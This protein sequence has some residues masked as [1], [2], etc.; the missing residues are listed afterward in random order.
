[1]NVNIVEKRRRWVRGLDESLQ[2]AHET[3]NHLQRGDSK[4][5]RK[6]KPK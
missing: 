5:E 4:G 1:M 2:Q 3:A 6:W